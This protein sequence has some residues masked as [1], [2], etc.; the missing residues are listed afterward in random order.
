MK[1]KII[2]LTAKQ[3]P[4][5]F[6]E[7]CLYHELYKT[8]NDHNFTSRMKNVFNGVRDFVGLTACI[9]YHNDKP[10]GMCLIE[11]L[12]YLHESKA[13]YLHLDCRERKNPWIKQ[14]DWSFI[15]LGL[16]SFYVKPE[17]RGIG[18]ANSLLENMEVFIASLH[19]TE[20][21]QENAFLITAYEKSYNIIKGSRLF[22][23]NHF[24]LKD[25]NYKQAI[26][27]HTYNIV[28]NGENKKT[29]FNFSES[30]KI[31]KTELKF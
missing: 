21:N 24:L 3:N 19:M 14:F 30:K 23:P 27:E 28:F 12:N 18:V 22:Y 5:K 8:D 25:R 6:F 29:I 2:H 26:S 9:A 17:Y 31:I 1:H 15:N 11:H 10:I 13:G 20:E 7:F 16:V 4:D